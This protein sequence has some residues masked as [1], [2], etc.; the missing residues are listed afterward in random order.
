MVGAAPRRYLVESSCAAVKECRAKPINVIA[1]EEKTFILVTY[2]R[3]MEAWAKRPDKGLTP[4]IGVLIDTG[5]LKN[6]STTANPYYILIGNRR[7]YGANPVTLVAKVATSSERFTADTKT[8]G[9]GIAI[10]T[11]VLLQN[12]N[13]PPYY[14]VVDNQRYYGR[15]PQEVLANFRAKKTPAVPDTTSESGAVLIDSGK[16]IMKTAPYFMALDSTCVYGESADEI[17]NKIKGGERGGKCPK[18]GITAIMLDTDYLQNT[19]PKMNGNPYYV[20]FNGWRVYGNSP[21]NV[22]ENVRT[23]LKVLEL[24]ATP[25]TISRIANG[26]RK[27]FGAAGTGLGKAAGAAGTGLAYVAAKGQAIGSA[28]KRGIMRG[29]RTSKRR[30]MR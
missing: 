12:N 9:V 17:F 29:G 19:N 16:L 26:T 1:S 10:D 13:K 14:I 25:T 11:A 7:L 27:A 8:D 21:E 22:I 2:T 30:R 5:A 15:T 18:S 4:G 20:L 3:I 24:P 28:I 23:N 6:S